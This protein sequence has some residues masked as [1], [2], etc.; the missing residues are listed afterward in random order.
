MSL[1]DAELAK[2][3]GHH[4]GQFAIH[5]SAF[6]FSLRSEESIR[7]LKEQVAKL[8][9]A[10]DGVMQEEVAFVKFS[11]CHT[12]YAACKTKDITRTIL[13]GVS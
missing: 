2:G 5:S 6:L 9:A 12:K 3:R 10:K 8:C 13:C 1:C 11:K 7:T 4:A